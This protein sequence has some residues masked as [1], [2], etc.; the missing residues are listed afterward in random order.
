MPHL[1]NVHLV[2]PDLAKSIFT[3][4]NGISENIED[5]I[6]KAAYKYGQNML[7]S[8]VT[9]AVTLI[10]TLADV[11]Q[12]AIHMQYSESNIFDEFFKE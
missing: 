6:A 5:I 9:R 1:D 7:S 3:P 12:T 10:S 4:Y 2:D 8:A 11:P